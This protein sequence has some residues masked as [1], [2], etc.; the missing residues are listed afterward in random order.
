MPLVSQVLQ[1][2]TIIKT[3][4]FTFTAFH[5]IRLGTPLVYFYSAALTVS[6][7]IGRLIVGCEISEAGFEA[8]ENLMLDN[9]KDSTA[10]YLK[11]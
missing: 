3:F 5:K 1:G 9:L 6:F 2:E 4:Q 11:Y 8:M 7:A 10:F